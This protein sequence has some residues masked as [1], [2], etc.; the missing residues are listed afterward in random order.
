MASREAR[1]IASGHA[2]RKH[3]IERNEFPGIATQDEFAE[4]IDGIMTSQALPTKELSRSRKAWWDS[5]TG[6]LVIADPNHPDAGTAFKPLN[7]ECYFN[8]LH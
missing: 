2:W 5:Q 7:G 3:V 1:R 4:L 8:S 6:C